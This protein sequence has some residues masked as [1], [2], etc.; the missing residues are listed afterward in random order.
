MMPFGNMRSP[1]KL[2]RGDPK[3]LR[4][5]GSNF[6]CWNTVMYITSAE[7][8]LSTKTPLV[9]YPSMVS[10]ITRGSLCGCLTPLA[11]HSKKTMSS[12]LD[13]WCLAIGCFI[14]TLLTC[15]WIAFFKDLYDPPTT[16]PPVIFLIYPMTFLG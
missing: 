12:S 10:M 2:I 9:L 11:S 1:L 6:I 16:G 7:L 14:W 3:G 4:H 13:W 8:P 15:L 5:F